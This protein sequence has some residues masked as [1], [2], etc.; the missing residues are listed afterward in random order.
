MSDAQAAAATALDAHFL[1]M[2]KWHFSPETGTP[3]WLNWAKNAG[4]D[5]REEL[6][7]F[8]DVVRFPTLRWRDPAQGRPQGVRSEGL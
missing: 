7:S 4:W 5:P 3:Y 1:E 2:L 8:A 6:K